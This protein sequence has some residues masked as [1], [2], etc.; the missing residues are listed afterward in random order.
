MLSG[1]GAQ[2]TP[3]LLENINYYNKDEKGRRG[4][5]EWDFPGKEACTFNGLAVNL[6]DVFQ[7]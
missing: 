2:T 5:C 7:R 6:T 4:A 3:S 1:A